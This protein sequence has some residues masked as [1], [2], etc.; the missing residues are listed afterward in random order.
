MYVSNVPLS[1]ACNT[2][3]SLQKGEKRTFRGYMKPTVQGAFNWRFTYQNTVDSTWADGQYSRADLPGGHF[4]IL[5]AGVCACG[6]DLNVLSAQTVCFDQHPDREVQPGD[7]VIS[8]SVHLAIPQDGYVMF[9]WCIEAL[10]EK[11]ILPATPDSRALVY[12][13]MDEQAQTAPLDAFHL[14][15]EDEEEPGVLPCLWEAERESVT[16]KM[17]F[18]GDS[19]TQGCQTRLNYYEQWAARI[20]RGLP[21]NIA[22]LNIGLGYARAQDAARNGAW[23]RKLRDFDVVNVCLGVN[24]IFQMTE[25]EDH[26]DVL[27]RN[28]ENTVRLIR[29]NTPHA[30]VVLFTIPPFSMEEKEE[31]VRESVNGC[32]RKTALGADAVFDM[33]I[34]AVPDT[35][36]K[37]RFGDH[38]DGVGGAAVAGEYLTHF[39]P[40]HQHLLF[41]KAK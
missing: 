22:G 36:G 11:C 7:I 1:H 2:F 31:A 27:S 30:K 17:A 40:E 28:L 8:D 37:A 26:A 6:K 18:I 19:I 3:Y 20:I 24:D 32:I 23:L 38:P 13:A 15:N 4:R 14:L 41:A 21:Q 10:E 12:I 33:E 16:H 35:R 9:S 5:H 34:L 29:Q 25:T 39:L